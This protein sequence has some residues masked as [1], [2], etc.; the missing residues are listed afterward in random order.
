MYFRKIG[1]AL[2]LVGVS[3]C[4]TQDASSDSREV[5]SAENIYSAPKLLP[6]ATKI[7]QIDFKNFTY[8]GPADY[9]VSFTLKNGAK[10]QARLNETGYSLL[11]VNYFDVTGDREEDAIV[12]IGIQTGGSATPVLVFVYSLV[13]DTPKVLWKFVSGDR[14]EGGLKEIYLE[15]DELVVELFGDAAY[16]DGSWTASVPMEK[17]RGDCCPINYTK[18]RFR[19]TGK[20]FVVQGRPEVIDIDSKSEQ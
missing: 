14:A 17:S 4:H 1:F 3:A 11:D 2:L 10:D 19:W 6:T 7:K 15:N 5:E 20:S 8:T 13:G 16:R 18:T 9:D 12:I